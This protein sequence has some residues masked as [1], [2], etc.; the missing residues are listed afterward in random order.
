[1]AVVVPPLVV[2]VTFWAPT[3]PTGVSAVIEVALTTTTL[4]AASPPTFTVAPAIKLVPVMVIGVPP[5]EEPDAGLTVVIVGAAGMLPVTMLE[6]K[7]PPV[8]CTL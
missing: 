5:L 8:A 6:N 7:V 4:V 2:T 3:V 1:M